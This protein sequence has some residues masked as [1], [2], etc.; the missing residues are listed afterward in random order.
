[1]TCLVVVL[2][3]LRTNLEHLVAWGVDAAGFGLDKGVSMDGGRAGASAEATAAA[4]G[5]EAGQTTSFVGILNFLMDA[6]G[7][8]HAAVL[9]QQ[10]VYRVIADTLSVGLPIFCPLPEERLAVLSSLVKKQLV[11]TMVREDASHSAARSLRELLMTRY[12]ARAI[13][14]LYVPY[15]RAPCE[16]CANRNASRDRSHVHRMGRPRNRNASREGISRR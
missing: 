11:E 12:A 4:G 5:G 10:E 9:S 3:A 15:G 1:M 8:S 6:G 2:R 16:M 13:R 14:T 7:A